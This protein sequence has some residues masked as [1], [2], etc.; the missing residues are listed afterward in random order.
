VGAAPRRD[1]LQLPEALPN[2]FTLGWQYAV[3]LNSAEVPM[4][5]QVPSSS[6]LRKGR[7]SLE[8]QIYLVTFVTDGR[9]HRFTNLQCGRLM[10]R[11]MVDSKRV[12]TL[13]FVVMPDHVHWLI[14]LL[15]DVSLSQVLHTAKSV[16]AHR[17]NNYLKR[18]GRFWQNGF[19][20]HALRKEE[21]IKDAARYIISNPVRAGIVSSVRDYPH[22]DAIWV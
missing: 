18:K 22:W 1:F 10:I 4:S 15:D 7:V 19:H 9:K 6:K 2:D 11:A 8:N 3:N 5:D 21:D 17:L 12:D 14:Q 20:D 13:A 16:S